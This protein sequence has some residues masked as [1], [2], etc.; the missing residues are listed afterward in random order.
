MNLFEY[1]LIIVLTFTNVLSNCLRIFFESGMINDVGLYLL[2]LVII[3]FTCVTLV[4]I[5][6]KREILNK[7]MKEDD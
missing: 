5:K 6:Y 4:C 2:G 1:L 3:F 7:I